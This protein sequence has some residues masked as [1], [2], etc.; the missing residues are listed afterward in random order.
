[1]FPTLAVT[2]YLLARLFGIIELWL[3]A[4][5]RHRN[6][7]TIFARWD[8]QWYQ[9]IAKDGYGHQVITTTRIFSNEAFFPLYPYAMRAIHR[10]TRLDYINSGI[11][12]SWLCGIWAV[13][14]IF[15]VVEKLSNRK[16]AL[17]TA[18]LWSIY[19]ISYV[20]SLAYSET[21]FTALIA[22]GL[23]CTQK[24]W[25]KLAATCAFL[26][27]LTRP[28]GLALAAA[29]ILPICYDLITR[30]EYRRSFSRYFAILFS[31]AG[32][33][34]YVI[35]LAIKN[36]DPFSYLSVQ[37]NFGN[38]L[39]GGRHFVIWIGDFLFSKNWYLGLLLIAASLAL[40]YLLSRLFRETENVHIL[41]FTTAVVIISFAT[42]GYFGS[43]PRYLLPAFPLL[44]PIAQWLEKQKVKV[45]NSL[46]L[47]F[48][49]VGLTYGAIAATGH[50]PP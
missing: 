7:F 28:T 11:L 9:S 38:G 46:Y 4:H 23:Y 45:R 41:I 37:R 10:L 14:M 20:D 49:I 18:T 34:T 25:I 35:F 5:L 29:I 44:I 32:W 22:T 47:L 16:I 43:K 2:F 48:A 30:P 15:L 39:D 6:F 40:F 27:G 21:L 33:L 3:V 26:A 50:G 36:D 13:L 8:A 19:P 42:S 24:S 31:G 12:I 17:V 1:V